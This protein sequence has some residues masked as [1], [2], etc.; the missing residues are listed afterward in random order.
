MNVEDTS[1]KAMVAIDGA[2]FD[3]SFMADEEVP[4]NMA[5]MAFSDSE[6]LNDKTCSNTCLKSFETLKTQ[7]D[8]LKIEFNKSE[9]D[10]ANYKRGLASVEEQLVF[11]KKNEVVFSE[12]IVVLKRDASFRDSEINALN[13][14]IEQ[15]KKEKESN[16][17]FAPP[18]IDLSSSGLEEFQQPEFE[19]YGVK[20]N[21]NVCENTSSE[22]K[23]TTDAPI[24]E[25]WFSDSDEDESEVVVSVNVQHKPEQA[26]QPR[27]VSENPRNNSTNWNKM[28]TQKLGVGFQFTKKACFVCGSFNHLIKDCDF[29]DKRMVQKPVLNNEKKM[30]SKREIRPVWNNAM[31]INHQNFSNPRRNFIPKAVLTKTGIVPISTARQSSSRA[32]APVSTARP[33]NTA[34]PKPFVNV[35]KPRP[36]AFQKSHSPSRRPF[37]QQTAL[38]NRNLNN[39]VK[40]AKANSIN[41]V[42]GKRVTSAVG[43]QGINVVKSS[44]CWVWRP[45][46]KEQ[47][48][49]SK[50]VDHTFVRDLTMLIQ[51]ANSSQ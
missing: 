5:L 3:W 48:H 9:F 33:I 1:S 35:T 8:N 28:K 16:K 31:R 25:E 21:K 34:G 2:R 19:D 49:V 7:Y 24:I 14:Q 30:T 44:A 51:H 15:L 26:D 41:T 50:T 39:N 32:A 4:T 46:I 10:L 13:I 40:T 18:S 37:Y 29:H 42:K 27:K 11:Y 17:L 23:K 47:D 6:V 22:I 45:K 38:K 20:V 36:N 12:Q 43:E